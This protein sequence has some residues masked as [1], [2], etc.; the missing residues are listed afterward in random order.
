LSGVF[1]GIAGAALIALVQELLTAVRRGGEQ[2][3]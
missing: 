1:L 2:G 3:R